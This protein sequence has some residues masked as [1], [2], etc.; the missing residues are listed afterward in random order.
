MLF[1]AK[2]IPQ[3]LLLDE[4]SDNQ[5]VSYSVP[6]SSENYMNVKK[7]NVNWLDLN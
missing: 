5:L 4:I 3:M 7:Y 2:D 6:L 1:K